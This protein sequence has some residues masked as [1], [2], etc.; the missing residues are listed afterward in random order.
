M[1]AIFTSS[2]SAEPVMADTMCSQYTTCS[3][4]AG[5]SNQTCI[6]FIYKV[7]TKCCV[8]VSVLYPCLSILSLRT[9]TFNFWEEGKKMD[10]RKV[11]WASVRHLRIHQNM[12]LN[13][14]TSWS[15]WMQF[16]LHNRKKTR[17]KDKNSKNVMGEP[18]HLWRA[19]NNIPMENSVQHNC[20]GYCHK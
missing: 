1:N 5:N 16:K 13:F 10:G 18:A 6:F 17:K 19:T 14:A 20:V 3:F 9:F 15:D 7:Y 12:A 2:S 11:S 4:I 8:C